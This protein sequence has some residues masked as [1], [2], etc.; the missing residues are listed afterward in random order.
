MRKM[1]QQL[2]IGTKVEIDGKTYTVARDLRRFQ[3]GSLNLIELHGE[4]SGT[5]YEIRNERP[6]TFV[7]VLEEK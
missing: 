4:D 7:T 2:E 6:G 3:N 5:G 1:L